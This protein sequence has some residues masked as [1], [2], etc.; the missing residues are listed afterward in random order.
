MTAAPRRQ[1]AALAA[2]AALS[3]CPSSKGHRNAN[4]SFYSLNLNE[5]QVKIMLEATEVH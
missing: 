5:W 2:M 4:G 1:K 3:P